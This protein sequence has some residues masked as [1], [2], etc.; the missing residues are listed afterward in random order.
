MSASNNDF[1]SNLLVHKLPVSK[2]VAKKALFNEVPQNWHI[3]VS[4]IRDSTSA[5]QK[6]HHHEV[7]LVA[8][9]SVI[10]VLNQAFKSNVRVPFFFG[11][12]GSVL[13]IP[14]DLLEKSLTVLSK[15]KTNSSDNFGLDLRVGN[16]PV[17][18]VYNHNLELKLAR[19]QITS[20][21]NI[22]L[23]LGKGLQFAEQQ[24]KGNE[25]A[26]SLNLDSVEL[27]LS[28]MECKWD[29]IEPPR[30]DQEVI[31]LIIDGCGNEEPSIVYSKVLKK[32]DKI[33]GSPLQRKPITAAKL[34]LKASLRQIRAE[35]KAKLGK[36]DPSYLIRNWL[37]GRFGEIYLKKTQAGRNYIQK[38]VELTD[39]LTIDG[40][41]NTVIT[42]TSSQRK[43]LLEYLDHL[44]S[45]SKIKYG[46]H[47]SR[48]SILSCYVWDLQTNDHIHFVDGGNGGYTSAARNLK[49]KLA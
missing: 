47:V 9:G 6:G 25:S 19:T 48:Q 44:E 2:L 4:D 26:Q 35:M 32:I 17:S 14:E 46:Y 10:A 40:R 41:I 5:I 16:V 29:R 34:K 38:L 27:D 42:G 12:D 23:V 28:G 43:S 36:S 22:P 7:N 31:S 39:N 15:H 21:L 3:L 18:E 11:G 37:M 1:Y 45:A 30:N 33:Y 20:L 8:T 49:A 24:I 13:I